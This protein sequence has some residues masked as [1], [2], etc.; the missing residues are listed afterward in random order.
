MATKQTFAVVLNVA[1]YGESDK[2]VTLYCHD[3]GKLAGIAKGAKRSKKRFVNKLEMFSLL[4][5]Q[6]ADN[7]RTNLIRIDNAELLDPFVKLRLDYSRYT[8]STLLCELVLHW[9]KENDGDT[10]LFDLLVWALNSLNEGQPVARTVILFQV[11]MLGVLGYRP[12]LE[13]CMECGRL[14]AEGVPYRFSPGRSGLV[15]AICSPKENIADGGP[16]LLSLNTAKLLHKAQEMD[17]QKLA[18]LHFSKASTQE[19]ISLL[20]RFDRYLLQREI[21]SWNYLSPDL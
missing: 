17:R 5:V 10:E 7:C 12:H 18:R 16:L 20:K 21:Q 3:H 9:T 2:I 13:G 15:C 1:D 11:K 19:A 14:D 8:A 4:D 6:Y